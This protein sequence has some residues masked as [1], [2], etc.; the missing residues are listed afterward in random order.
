MYPMEG[1]MNVWAVDNE[2]EEDEAEELKENEFAYKVL[3]NGTAEVTSYSSNEADITIPVT[4]RG[5]VCDI[6]WRAVIF[7][8]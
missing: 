5:Q 8:L 7:C 2:S 3:N 1:T 4:L 6:R